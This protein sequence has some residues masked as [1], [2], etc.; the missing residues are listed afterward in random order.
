MV[1]RALLSNGLPFRVVEH[2][3]HAFVTLNCTE[4][5]IVAIVDTLAAFS[6]AR[7]LT[8]PDAIQRIFSL[9]VAA[10]HSIARLSGP[11]SPLPTNP[12]QPLPSTTEWLLLAARE[13]AAAS[14]PSAL[15]Q[16]VDAL[17]AQLDTLA[18]TTVNSTKSPPIVD[19]GLGSL[20]AAIAQETNESSTFAAGQALGKLARL[21]LEVIVSTRPSAPFVDPE[22]LRFVTTSDQESECRL[23]L[24]VAMAC[25]PVP[26]KLPLM[27]FLGQ[28]MVR[29]RII[30]ACATWSEASTAAFERS[31]VNVLQ[32]FLQ[33]TNDVI[34]AKLNSLRLFGFAKPLSIAKELDRSITLAVDALLADPE[35]QESWDVQRWGG[36]F[37]RPRMARLFPMGV[38]ALALASASVDIQQRARAL[39]ALRRTDGFPYF[40]DFPSIPPD[41]DDLGIALQ[42]AACLPPDPQLKES[43]VWPVELLVRNVEPDGAIPVWF[44]RDLREPI[45]GNAPRWLGSRCLAA[46]ANAVVGLVE[47]NVTLAPKFL[48]RVVGWVFHTWQTEGMN[49]VFFYGLPYTRFILLRLAEVVTPKLEIDSVMRVVQ[50]VRDDL[51]ASIVGAR[52]SDGSLGGILASA[53]HLA[54]AMCVHDQ[55][56]DPWPTLSYLMAQQRPDGFW[57]SEPL[58]LTV[59]KDNVPAVHEAR[60]LTTALCLYALARTRRRSSA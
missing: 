4:P 7:H 11:V 52:R 26:D 18:T 33:A 45:P 41:A 22:L 53:C 29:A 6:A 24:A 48:D 30:E 47:A 38:C 39:L 55:T 32:T 27:S 13:R 37:E 2:F 57:P 10:N 23:R 49:A 31:N 9:L 17:I 3:A 25:K 58:Y 5:A 50:L 36:W 14:L 44:E 12:I 59:G 16:A 20:F 54:G 28:P 51:H 60:S 56:F 35:L 19:Y 8:D 34:A 15:E 1:S 40:E 46:A 21:T 42:L 43:L